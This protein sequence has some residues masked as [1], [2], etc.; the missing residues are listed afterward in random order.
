LTGNIP[1][2]GSALTNF[3]CNDNNLTGSIP[4]L[5]TNSKLQIFTC[6]NNSLTGTIPSLSNMPSLSAFVCYNQKGTNKLKGSIPSLSANS[7]LDNFSCSDN[8][9][10]GIIPNLN[11]NPFLNSFNCGNNQITGNI[12]SLSANTFLETFY[13]YNNQLTG[14]AGG[15]VNPAL[16]IFNATA[17]A[18]TRSAVDSI[19]GDV[20]SMA[21]GYG[22]FNGK[23]FLQGG[24]NSS[25]S[26]SAQSQANSLRNNRGWS[27]STN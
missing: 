9:L 8:Q 3:Q 26:L 20:Y 21:F 13:C 14:Y 25:P 27:V 23:L 5:N 24:T 11:N 17:N 10:T 15:G 7:V 22:I 18:L 6:Q 1:S 16:N 4:S 12:P 2:L 19:I